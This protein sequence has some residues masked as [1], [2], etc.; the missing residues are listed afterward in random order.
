MIRVTVWDEDR[1]VPEIF[2]VY[3]QGIAAAIRDFLQKDEELE[4]RVASMHEPE[5]GM[6]DEL[7]NST[8]VL[9][10]WSHAHHEEIPDELARKIANR[11][12]LGM[13]LLVLHS[14]HASKPFR[15]LMGTSCSLRWRDNV[16][17]RVWCVD[18]SHPIAKGIP[19]HFELEAEEMYGE[20]FDIPQPDELV[21][22]GWF[23]GGEVMRSGCCWHRGAGKVFFFQPGH[24]T[25]SAYHNEYV[26]KIL[27]NAVHWAAPT[28]WRENLDC[29]W[30]APLEQQ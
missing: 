10:W 9:L 21:F 30:T 12:L 6:P 17:E 19:E 13:G 24:E 14:S 7:L 15:F 4:V 27:N 16:F 8:D 3:P 28:C 25:N 29:R 11:V 22:V 23:G 18:P 5:F 1:Q 26:Q 20:H 2:A